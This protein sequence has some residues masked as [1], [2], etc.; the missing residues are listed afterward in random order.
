MLER[1]ETFH[2]TGHVHKNIKP[3]NFLTGTSWIDDHVLYLIDY[4]KCKPYLN[5]RNGYHIKGR[6]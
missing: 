4:K 6:V 3:Q 1:I 5:K 2:K